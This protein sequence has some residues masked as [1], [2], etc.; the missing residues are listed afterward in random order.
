MSQPCSYCG[1]VGCETRFHELLIQD[2]TDAGHGR[3][4]HL[5]VSSYM[6]QHD[7]YANEYL[8]T[9]LHGMKTWLHSFPTLQDRARVQALFNGAT[10]VKKRHRIAPATPRAWELTVFDV[11]TSSAETYQRTVR[12]WAS[13][14]VERLM[15]FS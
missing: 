15:A 4:H 6:V 9:V 12:A 3:V 8:E 2:F 7:F 1:A 14:I 5:V 11:D 10:R 13:S